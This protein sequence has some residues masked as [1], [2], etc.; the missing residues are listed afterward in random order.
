[1]MTH[2]YY[3]NYPLPLNVNN[4][5]ALLGRDA[6]HSERELY[7]DSWL[8]QR[9]YQYYQ[10]HQAVIDE[11]GLATPNMK[12]NAKEVAMLDQQVQ[13]WNSHYQNFQQTQSKTNEEHTYE[14]I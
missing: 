1:M 7:K 4:A 8:R 11:L 9:E 5:H 2:A 3:N 10:E 6:L 13:T 14:I 12:I